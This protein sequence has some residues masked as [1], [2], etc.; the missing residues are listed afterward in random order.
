MADAE[1]LKTSF[2]CALV[3]LVPARSRSACRRGRTATAAGQPRILAEI[4]EPR[5]EELLTL[6][7]MEIERSGMAEQIAGGVVL[8]GGSAQLA[9]LVE[10]TEQIFN[11]PARMGS[12]KGVSGLSDVVSN[13]KYSTAVG[14]VLY[15]AKNINQEKF[16]IRDTNIFNRVA[17]RMRR[18]FKD[19]V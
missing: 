2:G 11:M 17:G 18:W 12:P 4:L 7:Q 8:T 5:V 1:S 9:G 14:L 16:R 19:I 15:G 13:P 6:L 10:M 3:E